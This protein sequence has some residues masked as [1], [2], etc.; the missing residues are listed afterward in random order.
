ML[1]QGG[2]TRKH[3][4][5]ENSMK[6]PRHSEIPFDQNIDSLFLIHY[7]ASKY[8]TPLIQSSFTLIHVYFV[9]FNV[10]TLP[11]NHKVILF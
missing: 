9:L 10:K 6:R 5:Q 1:G 3:D 8:M 7:I 11:E 4:S 2:P